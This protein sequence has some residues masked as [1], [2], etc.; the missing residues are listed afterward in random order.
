MKSLAEQIGG[1][2]SHFT[3]IRE[4]NQSC[5][6]GVVYATVKNKENK[7]LAGFPCFVEGQGV[8]CDKR[9]F[10]TQEEVA[11]EVAEHNARWERLKL[12]MVSARE[13]AE[14]RGFGIGNSGRGHIVCPVCKTGE[15]HYSVAGYNGHLHGRCSTE[16]CVQ[17]MQ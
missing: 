13:D 15:L 11:A 2:C 10:P 17:W 8:P 5:K 12:A 1:R 4:E 9:H 16:K 6:A 14:K 3:G 7:G